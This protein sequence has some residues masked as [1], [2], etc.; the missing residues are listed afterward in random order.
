MANLKATTV[1]SGIV[2]EKI[3][4]T[5]ADSVS[6]DYTNNLGGG[7]GTERFY[8]WLEGL[9]GSQ[10]QRVI[11]YDPHNARRFVVVYINATGAGGLKRGYARIGIIKG[12]EITYSNGYVFH[13]ANTWDVI[14]AWDP[15]VANKLVITYRDANGYHRA[16][17]G[18]ISALSS[19]PTGFQVTFGAEQ[20]VGLAYTFKTRLHDITFDLNGSSGDS[21]RFCITSSYPAE[22]DGNFQ[23]VGVVIAGRVVNAGSGTTI[24]W[25]TDFTY[26]AYSTSAHNARIAYDPHTAGRLLIAWESGTGANFTT[27]AHGLIRELT[28]NTSSM[29]IT[30]AAGFITTFYTGDIK[31]P[32]IAWDPLV[33]NKFSVLYTKDDDGDKGAILFGWC[34]A[35]AGFLSG[36]VTWREGA[37]KFSSVVYDSS[38]E[39]F[40]GGSNG[41][42]RIIISFQADDD[43]DKGKAR[44]LTLTYGSQPY[45]AGASISI[46]NEAIFNA[47]VTIATM[48]SADYKL[49]DRYIIGFSDESSSDDDGKVITGKLHGGRV[50]IDLATGSF[51]TLDLQTVDTTI[52]NFVTSNVSTGVTTF[53]LRVIQGSPARYFDWGYITNVKWSSIPADISATNNAVDVYSFTTY[54]NGT[55]W[56]GSVVGQDIR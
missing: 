21:G 5:P 27:G 12:T 36:S 20:N 13:D 23:D 29:A 56:Y 39:D 28:V 42:G 44:M 18:T 6:A 10:T 49:P 24:S 53:D 33:T 15:L 30:A 16:K 48:I 50:T 25:G 43:G 46:G 35:G 8:A 32:C 38:Y 26:A 2:S 31:H 41:K 55:T 51:F 37:T 54:D 47:E 34:V 22:Q 52:D 3:G 9:F 19:D 7:F 1:T 45:N 14:F 17:V 4:T 11:Q 40:S